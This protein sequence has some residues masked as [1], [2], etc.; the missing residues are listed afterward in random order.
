[1]YESD[2]VIGE[3]KIEQKYLTW[4]KFLMYLIFREKNSFDLG[5]RRNGKK[6]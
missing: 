5:Q 3:Q 4:Y 2:I 1:M 6:D